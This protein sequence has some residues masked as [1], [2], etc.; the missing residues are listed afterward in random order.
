MQILTE[1]NSGKSMNEIAKNMKINIKTVDRWLKRFRE[2]NSVM[3]KRGT[4]I[5]N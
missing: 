2:T 1:Y 3:R 5:R 4:G